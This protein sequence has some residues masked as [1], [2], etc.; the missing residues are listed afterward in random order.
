MYVYV[1]VFKRRQLLTYPHRH[2]HEE[3]AEGHSMVHSSAP[4]SITRKKNIDPGTFLCWSPACIKWLMVSPH[5]LS[6][7]SLTRVPN[8][9][10]V[11]QSNKTQQDNTQRKCEKST[12]FH[13]NIAPKSTVGH[14]ELLDI[15]PHV[16]GH[17]H[18]ALF[19]LKAC[20]MSNCLTH[21][22]QIFCISDTCLVNT[23]MKNSDPG[24]FWWSH[25]LY[26]IHLKVMSQ[27][28]FSC[29]F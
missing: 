16:I 11:I 23:Y 28:P 21:F 14:S 4:L 5:I 1:Y 25:L 8:F 2:L 6:I 22:F 24:G 29:H 3:Q 18:C 17:V 27:Q 15:G 12:D 20:S 13:P 10:P 9:R 26:H 7:A 19:P